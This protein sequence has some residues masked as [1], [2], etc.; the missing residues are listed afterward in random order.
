MAIILSGTGTD[1][2]EKGR[3][4][5]GRVKGKTEN[6]LIALFDQAYMFRP[7]YIQPTK[8]L[9]NAYKIYGLF[10]PFYPLLK[11]AFPGFVT[12]LKEIGLAMINVTLRKFPKR[13]LE[14]KDIAQ[15]AKS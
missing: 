13:V 14:N 11:G 7:G 10:A 9:N 12:S 8:G 5:W 4:M 3:S 1:G 2:S 15:A 6:D